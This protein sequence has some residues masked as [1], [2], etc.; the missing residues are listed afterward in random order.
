MLSRA[1]RTG[2]WIWDSL[3]WD[4]RHYEQFPLQGDKLEVLE[5]AG[6]GL[7][8]GN[9][10]HHGLSDNAREWQYN[11]VRVLTGRA[12]G[13]IGYAAAQSRDGSI[14]LYHVPAGCERHKP[15]DEVRLN[16]SGFHPISAHHGDGQSLRVSSFVVIILL[17]AVLSQQVRSCFLVFVPTI[18]EIRE[19]YREM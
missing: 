3:R 16:D 2:P 11:R 4:A 7:Q 6:P 1:C 18:R 8:P 10:I 17:V 13:I 15:E 14:E 5:G 12:A 19:F 9:G